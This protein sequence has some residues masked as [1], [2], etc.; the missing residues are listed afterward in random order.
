[1]G[2]FWATLQRVGSYR[3]L[4]TPCR[5]SALGN[6]LSHI[7]TQVSSVSWVYRQGTFHIAALAPFMVGWW[8]DASNFIFYLLVQVYF[9]SFSR[10]I[11]G[12]LY[13]SELVIII[14]FS[15]LPILLLG[16]CMFHET[17]YLISTVVPAGVGLGQWTIS[18]LFPCL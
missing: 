11:K 18:T 6:I 16:D 5:I 17:S 14:C 13:R 12:F 1:M 9:F 7:R 2:A 10:K 15:I 3:D 4:C 8:S